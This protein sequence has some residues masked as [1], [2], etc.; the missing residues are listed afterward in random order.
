MLPP[1]FGEVDRIAVSILNSPTL[2]SFLTLPLRCL[3]Y[4]TRKLPRHHALR[5]QPQPARCKATHAAVVAKGVGQRGYKEIPDQVV[6][7]CI[8]E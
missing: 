2:H 4:T 6:L 1:F 7:G 8:E 5:G 3:E